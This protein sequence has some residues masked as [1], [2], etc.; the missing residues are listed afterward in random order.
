MGELQEAASR[1]DREGFAMRLDWTALR[2]GA[3][4]MSA[5]LGEWQHGWQYHASSASEHHFRETMVL[6][7]ACPSDQ[8]ALEV[9]FGTGIER[10][11][12]GSSHGSRVQGTARIFPHIGVGEVA[13]P[14][15]CGRSQV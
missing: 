5:E 8:A 6:S 4:V 14:V 7:S 9:S 15:G 2:D 12:A 13:A 10:D 11:P 3:L 1:L